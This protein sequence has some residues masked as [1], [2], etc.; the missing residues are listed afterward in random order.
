VTGVHTDHGAGNACDCA[1]N[2]AGALA[3]PSQSTLFVYSDRQ[4]VYWADVGSATIRSV[5]RGRLDEMPVGSGPS[6]TCLMSDDTASFV[7]DPAL[8]PA[9]RGF[10]YLMRAQNVCGVVTY[11]QASDGTPRVTSACP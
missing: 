5:V 1:P 9:G 7:T 4:T 3:P 6:E 2:D 10:W 11:G 8:P